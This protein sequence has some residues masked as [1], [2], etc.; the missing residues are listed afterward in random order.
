M[1]TILLLSVLTILAILICSCADTTIVHQDPSVANVEGEQS[2]AVHSQRLSSIESQ[3]FDETDPGNYVE[4]SV[5]LMDQEPD[6]PDEPEPSPPDGWEPIDDPDDPFGPP[7]FMS[8]S[9]SGLGEVSIMSVDDL[10]AL[11]ATINSSSLINEFFLNEYYSISV[12]VMEGLL[13]ESDISNLH[14]DYPNL[15]AVLSEHG[16]GY[17]W[18]EDPDV[19]SEIPDHILAELENPETWN[20]LEQVFSNYPELAELNHTQFLFVFQD[21]FEAYYDKVL[22]YLDDVYVPLATMGNRDDECNPQHRDQCVDNAWKT[23]MV[24][25]G[26]TSTLA[27][28]ATTW[29]L[30]QAYKAAVIPPAFKAAVAA[31]IGFP[32]VSGLVSFGFSFIGYNQTK[33]QC[34]LWFGEPGCQDTTDPSEFISPFGG[35]RGYL[36][37]GA[38]NPSPYGGP[39]VP[40]L[41]A[42][43]ITSGPEGTCQS[44][45]RGWQ[46]CKYYCNTGEKVDPDCDDGT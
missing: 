25:V 43:P 16:P 39:T 31:C 41:T 26:V 37:N 44:S 6:P 32:T 42:G 34:H 40:P 8:S 22:S 35:G 17:D 15:H 20:S 5:E 23:L 19:R 46:S 30:K 2:L 11:R 10:E 36:P 33:N 1:R 27:L 29:C 18:S 45:T 21:I 9:D 3:Q 38:V 12:A 13:A 4:F 14:L 7:G 24:N 28:G